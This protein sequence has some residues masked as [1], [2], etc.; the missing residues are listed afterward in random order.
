MVATAEKATETGAHLA[1]NAKRLAQQLT[2]EAQLMQ[3]GKTIIEN[4]RCAPRLVK[5]YGGK[6]SE[7]VKKGSSSYTKDGKNF[8]THWYEN[9]RTGQ[10]VEQKTKLVKGW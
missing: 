9:L 8:R 1:T 4:L 6:A 3:E 2:S 5:Q 7:W 10:R